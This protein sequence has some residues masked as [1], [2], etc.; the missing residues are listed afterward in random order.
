MKRLF[1]AVFLT[2]IAVSPLLAQKREKR[3]LVLSC[4][5]DAITLAQG[6]SVNLTVTIENRGSS[7]FYVY[8]TLEWGWAGIGYKLTNDKG[9]I[10]RP[11]ER[12]IPLP[13]PPVTDKSKLVGLAPGYFFGTHLDFDLSRYLLSPGIYYVE[14]SYQ[15]KYGTESGFGLPM[16]TPDDGEFRCKEI[17]IQ[18]HPK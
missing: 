6:D 12:V 3:V 18:V 15:S 1:C 11:R 13:P 16:L 5:A 4:T 17:Q 7:D 8:H 9:D 10:V 2:L 14:V